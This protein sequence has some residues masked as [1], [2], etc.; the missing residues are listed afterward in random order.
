M[1]IPRLYVPGD[2]QPDQTLAL[3]TEQA[4][5]LMPV[6]RLKAEHPLEVFDGQG[7][8]AR[9]TLVPESKKQ[10]KVALEEIFELNR[11][12]PLQTTL[13][14]SVS[15]GDRMD[16]SLQKAVELGVSEIQPVLTEH[17]MVRLT[18]EKAQKRQQQW[19][20]IVIHACEQCG[21]T[22]VPPVRPL[23]TYQAWL[24]DQPDEAINGLVLDPRAQHALSDLSPP[25]SPMAFLVGPEGGLSDAEIDQAMEKG[26]KA[27]AL[28]PRVLRTE[29]AGV[30][31]LA[32]MQ[33]LWGDF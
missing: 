1:R 6:L 16:Y 9:A 23:K 4:H 28:G 26:L 19:Q 33:T 24:K 20:A 13:V 18:P 8:Q 22:I 15:K 11:E 30:T 25:Q 27:I 14:Q 12:S 10:A 7:H 3:S 2:Y 31:L 32:A 29:T 5:Y 21:R 17:S